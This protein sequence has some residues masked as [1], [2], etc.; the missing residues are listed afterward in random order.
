[1]LEIDG[2]SEGKRSDAKAAATRKRAEDGILT[3]GDATATFYKKSLP[4]AHSGHNS[5]GKTV[6]C[7]CAGSASLCS[8]ASL[9]FLWLLQPH[10]RRATA[11]SKS[12]A[13]PAP[14]CSLG[15]AAR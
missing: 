15:A 7:R 8:A 3:E 11:C 12:R 1:M 6:P 2:A 10:T 14:S 9:R 5:A 13:R 4:F